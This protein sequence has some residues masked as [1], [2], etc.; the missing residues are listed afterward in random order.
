MCAKNATIIKKPWGY[1]KLFALTRQY[2]GKFLVINKG[3][4]LSL[5]YHE[6][7]DETLYVLSGT[8]RLT[9]GDAKYEIVKILTN[10][11]VFHM[12]PKTIHRMYAVRKCVLVEVSTPHLDDVVR[13]QDDYKRETKRG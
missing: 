4:R 1:E 5:Q 10:N 3:H 7:K 12:P 2:A 8:L 6:K 11:A 9:I 13:L